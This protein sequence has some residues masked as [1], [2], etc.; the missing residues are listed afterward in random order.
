MGFRSLD[1]S[2]PAELHIRNHQLIIEKEE[3]T[4][5]VPVND[6]DI[7][8]LH[9]TNIRLS[10]MDLSILSENQVLLM[11][12]GKDYLPSSMTLSFRNNSRQSLTM[13]KQLEL[14]RRRTNHL[15]NTIIRSKISNQA[16]V[17]K[18]LGL[19]GAEEIRSMSN[20]VNRGDLDNIEAQAASAYFQYYHPGLN[21]RTE[22]PLNS[23]LNYGY[24]VIRSAV[25]RAAAA[26]GFLL[27][28]GIHHRS[29]LN[30]FNLVDDLIEPFRP[31]A[32]LQAYYTVT[33]DIFLSRKQRKELMGI[34]YGE[35]SIA[36]NKTTV[37][38]A[39]D[40]MVSSIRRYITEDTGE[41]YMPEL[42]IP[43]GTDT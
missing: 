4:L 30:A 38:N 19:P 9:G 41:L 13:R 3:D 23:C 5:S 17:L 21:R 15:W 34:L 29:M 25:A 43:G 33:G 10:A 32:D 14:S 20:K 7:L 6:L 16:D 37:I 12:V 40:V 24:S 28:A 11:T 1:I 31:F 8:I 39:A 22:T 42:I 18:I 36:G 35:C 2:T 26:H 27:S